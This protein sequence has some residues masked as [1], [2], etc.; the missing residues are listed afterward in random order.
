MGKEP[1]Y[2]DRNENNYGPAPKCMEVLKNVTPDML[3]SYT[4]AYKRG[5]KSPLSERLASD[6]QVTENQVLLGYG[7]EDIL[8]QVV[9]CYLSSN[10]KLMIPSHSW[11]YY[12]EIANEVGG[13]NIEY[14]MICEP[15]A[16][17]HGHSTGRLLT[18]IRRQL[19]KASPRCKRCS[20][21]RRRPCAECEPTP[22]AGAGLAVV[23]RVG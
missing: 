13:V 16:A 9:Q 20:T 8:K 14:P 5:V 6:F 4:K 17:R 2:L 11:W 1:V 10:E 22:A 21:R 15:D 7:A 18:N 19:I 23:A 3:S 12:K